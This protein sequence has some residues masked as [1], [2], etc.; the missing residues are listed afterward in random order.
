MI[1]LF[2]EWLKDLGFALGTPRIASHRGGHISL[3]HEDAFQISVAMRKI[4]KV[5]PDFRNPNVIRASTGVLFSMNIISTSSKE[6]IDYCKNSKIQIVAADPYA[7]I[8]SSPV[9]DVQGEVSCHGN[10][11]YDHK[12]FREVEF[13]II[14]SL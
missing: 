7:K 13:Q 3:L 11:V 8:K 12:A 6:I 14:K 5:F 1:D 2:E 10:V 9:V 4:S